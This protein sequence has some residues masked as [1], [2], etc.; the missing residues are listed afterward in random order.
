[1]N[2]GKNIPFLSMRIQTWE[3]KLKN[4]SQILIILKWTKMKLKGKML[5]LI[6]VIGPK[7]IIIIINIAKMAYVK[8]KKIV[9][10]IHQRMLL[11]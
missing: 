1:M 10:F 7:F 6:I 5:V 3:N 4:W 11:A 8:M 9:W 2:L